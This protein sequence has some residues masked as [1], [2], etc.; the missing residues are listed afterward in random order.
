MGGKLN[1]SGRKVEWEWER[2]WEVGGKWEGS[3]KEV[4]GEWGCVSGRE[5]WGEVFEKWESRGWKA[6]GKRAESAL[7]THINRHVIT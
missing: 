2:S 7:H 1:R 3:V 4:R 6:N 5:V